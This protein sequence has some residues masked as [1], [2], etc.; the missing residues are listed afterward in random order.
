MYING[1]I[2]VFVLA[3]VD[4]I[5]IAKNSYSIIESFKRFLD[6][7]FKIKDFGVLHYF[8]G[9]EALPTCNGV[10]FNQRKYAIELI[11]EFGLSA[12]KPAF[13]H[14]D[15]GCKLDDVAS[16]NN[17]FLSNINVISVWLES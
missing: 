17:H 5:L 15:Q 8:L 1:T 11:P 10:Y 7:K 9:I 2:N 6:D 14:M 13:V 12:N 16:D 4:D 3:Y